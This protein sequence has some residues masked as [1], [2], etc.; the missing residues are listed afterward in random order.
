MLR[1]L[2]SEWCTSPVPTDAV[3]RVRTLLAEGHAVLCDD[4]VTA[5]ER[6]S[7]C[8]SECRAASECHPVSK[9]VTE[10]ARV[11]Q[12]LCLLQ[13]AAHVDLAQAS[14]ASPTLPQASAALLARLLACC[15]GP[16]PIAAHV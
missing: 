11:H 9:P 12:V 13:H 2:L 7:S 5:A 8:V 16:K 4:V 6:L 10:A 1:T 14:P 3:A 15:R